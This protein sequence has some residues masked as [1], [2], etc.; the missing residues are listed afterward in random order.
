MAVR[1][2]R[3]SS[4]GVILINTVIIGLLA[5]LIGLVTSDP[6]PWLIGG[7]LIGLALS[8]GFEILCRRW[9]PDSRRYRHRLLILIVIELLV[10]VY[11][12]IPIYYGYGND[13]P[14]RFPITVTPANVNLTLKM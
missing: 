12:G 11:L 14:V 6:W 7:A 4:R 10:I 2:H 5:S 9:P 3:P 13:H 1:T 8:W